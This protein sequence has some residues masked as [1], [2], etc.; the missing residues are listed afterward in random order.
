MP[1][2]SVVPMSSWVLGPAFWYMGM[3]LF[4]AIPSLSDP[5]TP[6]DID[7]PCCDDDNR[8]ER[9]RAFKHHEQLGARRQW[10][11]IGGAEHCRGR[12]AEEQVVD[13]RR[14]PAGR[15]VFGGSPLLREEPIRPLTCVVCPGFRA[16]AIDRQYSSEKMSMLVTHTA[17]L[18]AKSCRPLMS[19][20]RCTIAPIRFPRLAR[21]TTAPITKK[22]SVTVRSTRSH[23][24]VAAVNPT[25]AIGASTATATT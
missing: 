16:A 14:P 18:E 10:H 13:E 23:R 12:V 22:S 8:S 24:G 15:H 9:D 17:M 7:R 25:A 5:L 11:D 4:T 1:W 19:D 20:G 2:G 6:E 3:K 21:V